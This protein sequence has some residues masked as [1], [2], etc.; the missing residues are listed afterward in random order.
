MVD[1]AKMQRRWVDATTQAKLW[2]TFVVFG[3]V[4]SGLEAVRVLWMYWVRWVGAGVKP[5]P[6]VW[7]LGETIHPVP[8]LVP[9]R[10]A[11]VY[12]SG[13]P[14]AGRQILDLA[15]F[16]VVC[17]AHRPMPILFWA[18]AKSA[19]ILGIVAGFGP[20]HVRAGAHCARAGARTTRYITRFLQVSPDFFSVMTL[21]FSFCH[22]II[23]LMSIMSIFLS[24]ITILKKER[25]YIYI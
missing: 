1:D 8:G 13:W 21:T 24:I 23:R 9:F 25:I 12:W 20:P 17:P 18:V 2:I 10:V 3:F 4:Y 7:V 5:S 15:G 16:G 14:G 6:G 19:K 22:L 11:Q